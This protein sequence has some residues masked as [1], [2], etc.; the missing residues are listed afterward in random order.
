M[1][2]DPDNVFA[3][4]LRG[5]LPCDKVLESEHSLAFRDLNPQAPA[6]VLV[7]PKQAYES[8]DDFSSSASAAEIEDLVRVLGRVARQLGIVESGYR[9][10]TNCGADGHQDV[11][12]FHVHVFGGADLGRMITRVTRAG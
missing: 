5:E 11:Q 7:I 8:F 9:L 12:H 1:V 3:K 6:H 4:I 2:Y 10:L